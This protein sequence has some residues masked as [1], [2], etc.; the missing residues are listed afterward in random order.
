MAF[1][2]KQTRGV[3][4][5]RND[6]TFVACVSHVPLAATK[7]VARK[8]MIRISPHCTVGEIERRN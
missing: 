3:F 2:W 6:S 1:K 5:V 8:I 7:I 4:A